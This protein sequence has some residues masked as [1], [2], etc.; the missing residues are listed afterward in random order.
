M[1]DQVREH[2]KVLRPLSREEDGELP[3][4]VHWLVEIVNPL[5][6]SYLAAARI[7]QPLLGAGETRLQLLHRA[8]Y[9]SQPAAAGLRLRVESERQVGDYHI[10]VATQ[11]LGEALDTLPQP[12]SVTRG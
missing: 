2:A 7:G 4:R 6:V 1:S 8:G 5:R 10:G 9:K 12:I 11:E 3:A